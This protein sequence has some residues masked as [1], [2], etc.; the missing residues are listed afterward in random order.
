MFDGIKATLEAD[1]VFLNI[2]LDLWSGARQRLRKNSN[3]ENRSK[4]VETRKIYSSIGYWEKYIDSIIDSIKED[5]DTIIDMLINGNCID[6]NIVMNLSR[7]EAPM[8]RVTID[9][10]GQKSPFEEDEEE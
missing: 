5:K 3:F 7:G 1:A 4:I 9:K 10:I 8:Y 6:A 2:P